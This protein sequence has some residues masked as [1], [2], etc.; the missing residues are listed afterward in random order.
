M[1]HSWAVRNHKQEVSLENSERKMHGN[2]VGERTI[3]SCFL[4][5]AMVTRRTWHEISKGKGNTINLEIYM[6]RQYPSEVKEI[7]GTQ[8][9]ANSRNWVPAGPYKHTPRGSSQEAGK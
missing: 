4:L 3:K 5:E 6:K 2:G 9:R 7:K 1:H 8:V